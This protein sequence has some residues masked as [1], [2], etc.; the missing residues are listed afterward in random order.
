MKIYLANAYQN[1]PIMLE[2]VN[3]LL[4]S[5]ASGVNNAAKRLDGRG[6]THVD[7][8]GEPALI[9]KCYFRGGFI[10]SF[11]RQTYIGLADRRSRMLQ[12]LRLLEQIQTLDLPGPKPVAVAI[13]RTGFLYQGQLVTEFIPNAETLA[14]KIRRNSASVLH[15]QSAGATIR[16]FHLKQIYHA[17]LNATNI[18]FDEKDHCHLIDFDKGCKKKGDHWKQKTLDRLHRSIKKIDPQ[19]LEENW[20]VLLESYSTV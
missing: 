6:A 9:A 4:S 17:D 7:E 20:T 12:E 8:S 3:H 18:L 1:D 5:S 13:N 16:A 15:W 11:N 19:S 10:A 14:Q 2:R